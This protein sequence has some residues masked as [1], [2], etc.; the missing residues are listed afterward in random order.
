MNYSG[1]TARGPM[2][3]NSKGGMLPVNEEET[4][5]LMKICSDFGVCTHK[6]RVGQYSFLMYNIVYSCI[7]DGIVMLVVSRM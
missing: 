7:D 5:I 1:R 6:I 2:A 3:W 4:T